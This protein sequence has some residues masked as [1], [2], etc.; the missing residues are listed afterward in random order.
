VFGLEVNWCLLKSSEE[1]KREERETRKAQ[2]QRDLEELNEQRKQHKKCR[3]WAS[4]RQKA[5][6]PL[7]HNL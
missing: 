2:V 5:E 7:R 6:L 3:N 4:T 1:E